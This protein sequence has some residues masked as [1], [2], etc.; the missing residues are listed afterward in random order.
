MIDVYSCG[1]VKTA[2]GFGEFN[3]PWSDLKQH[4]TKT[5]LLLYK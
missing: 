3:N 5:G 1:Q 2:Y 4:L